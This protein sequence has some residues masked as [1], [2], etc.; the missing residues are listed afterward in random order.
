[1]LAVLIIKINN[2]VT[3][4]QGM[5]RIAGSLS[6]RCC[7]DNV[8]VLLDVITLYTMYFT[9]LTVYCPSIIISQSCDNDKSCK[10]INTCYWY[11]TARMICSNSK[12]LLQYNASDIL[13]AQLHF[14]NIIFKLFVLVPYS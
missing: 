6:L 10:A 5:L 3:R 7:G 14:F 2:E 12:M 1:M 13:P 9:V 4:Q 11:V 8:M